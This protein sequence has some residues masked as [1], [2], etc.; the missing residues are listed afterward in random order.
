MLMNSNSNQ[1]PD[2]V[3]IITYLRKQFQS[4]FSKLEVKRVYTKDLRFQLFRN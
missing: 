4:D 2:M 3:C 1:Y